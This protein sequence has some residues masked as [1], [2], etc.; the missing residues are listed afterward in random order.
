M[1]GSPLCS[2][3]LLRRAD[4]VFRPRHAARVVL[5]HGTLASKVRPPFPQPQRPQPMRVK[6]GGLAHQAT[7][8][9]RPYHGAACAVDSPPLPGILER[10][11]RASTPRTR[12]P[13]RESSTPSPFLRAMVGGRGLRACALREGRPLTFRLLA[14]ARGVS[15]QVWRGGGSCVCSLPSPPRGGSGAVRGRVLTHGRI[16]TQLLDIH[17]SVHAHPSVLKYC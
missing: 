16:H 2:A 1:R 14:R 12:P 3:R 11:G 17:R 10:A 7:P 6:P 13:R 4:G 15:G 5:P 8:G 9:I